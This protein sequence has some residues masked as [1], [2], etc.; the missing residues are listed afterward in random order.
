MSAASSRSPAAATQHAP[1][2]SVP[3]RTS[4]RSRLIGDIGGTNARFAIAEKGTVGEMT[5]LPTQ[6]HPTFEHAIRTYLEGLSDADGARE[7]AFAI[8]GPVS[9]DRITFTNRQSW[10]FSIAALRSRLGLDRLDIVND[11]TANALSL[12]YLTPDDIEKV[13]GGAAVPGGPMGILGPGTGLGVSGLIA[14]NGGWIALAGEGG[15]ATLP[16]A[17]AREAAVVEYLRG[18]YGHVS[19]ERLLSGQGLVDLHAAL[20]T[21]DG[22]TVTAKEPP[23]ITEAALDGTD[24]RARETVDTFCAVLGTVAGDL[25]LTLGA[26]GGI[27]IAGGIVPRLGTV[28][29]GSPFRKRFEFKGRM[30]PFNAAIP[31]FVVTHQAP[32]MIGLANLP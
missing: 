14:K 24:A 11:F 27:Y 16:A 28:F 22:V 19:A 6:D 20:A 23:E 1:R 8:A 13:G 17:S 32:A 31:T 18:K 2:A 26:T 9:G 7:A 10:T 4:G 29:A 12:P 5:I 30:S 3:R 25:A 15:H 21:I